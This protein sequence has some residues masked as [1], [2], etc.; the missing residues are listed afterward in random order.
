MTWFICCENNPDDAIDINHSEDIY[1]II[2]QSKHKVVKITSSYSMKKIICSGKIDP[3]IVLVIPRCSK[4]Y[5]EHFA[6]LDSIIIGYEDEVSMRYLNK[7]NNVTVGVLD[8]IS[9]SEPWNYKVEKLTCGF[10]SSPLKLGENLEIKQ[11][12]TKFIVGEYIQE[13]LN[14][15]SY[16][17]TIE[18]C[19]NMI[20]H[21]V[22]EDFSKIVI[23]CV[24]I[25]TTNV[26][27]NID[28]ILS[29]PHVT[30][31]IVS[32]AGR[33]ICTTRNTTL[34]EIILGLSITYDDLDWVEENN[35]HY[36]NRRFKSTKAIM[37]K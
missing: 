13:S 4:E 2:K 18:I 26:S 5:L 12:D 20:G 6:Y 37:P 29:N 32:G 30:K 31:I 35:Y 3:A 8:I 19:A 33:V 25:E 23:D 16:I 22:E 17:G 15:F 11:F 10:V 1:P 24:K 34:R 27:F 28:V 14:N 7:P 36:N 9:H 21:L